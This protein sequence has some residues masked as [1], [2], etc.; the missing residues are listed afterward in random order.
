MSLVAHHAALR[1]IEQAGAVSVTALQILLEFQRDWARNEHYDEVMAT[2]KAH[3]SIFGLGVN[4]PSQ[5]CAKEL[6]AFTARTATTSN[7]NEQNFKNHKP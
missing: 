2:V 4:M 1:R 7:H 3:C 6:A 5:T